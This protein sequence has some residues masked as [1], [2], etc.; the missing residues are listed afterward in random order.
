MKSKDGFLE[1]GD[2]ISLCHGLKN[3]HGGRF[4]GLHIYDL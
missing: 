3:G 4:Y 1:G 2:I